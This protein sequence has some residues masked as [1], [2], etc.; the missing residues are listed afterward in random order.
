MYSVP[1]WYLKDLNHT[2]FPVKVTAPQMEEDNVVQDSFC[3]YF[4]ES[5]CE[6]A[7]T[8]DTVTSKSLKC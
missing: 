4:L 6:P 8:E 1:L 7:M 5:R 3:R 2:S